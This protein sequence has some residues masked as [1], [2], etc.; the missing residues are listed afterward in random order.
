MAV[1]AVPAG[2]FT[3]ASY[4]G[5]TVISVLD[6][7]SLEPDVWLVPLLPFLVVL[8]ARCRGGY[9][10]ILEFNGISVY[11]RHHY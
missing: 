6:V 9:R 10:S 1:V 8:L 4:L 3:A 5:P 2:V 11:R 7:P